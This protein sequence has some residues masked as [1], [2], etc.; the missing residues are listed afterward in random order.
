MDNMINE[1][2]GRRDFIGWAASALSS[3]MAVQ[4]LGCD[5]LNNSP[6]GEL[7][8]RISDNH[9]HMAVISEAQL[10][11]GWA[12]TLHIQGSADHDHTV[13]FTRQDM[14]NI[15]SGMLVSGTSSTSNGHSHVV[16]FD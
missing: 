9:G 3:V 5:A 13:D 4:I 16:S 15:K 10:N 7:S 14:A 6:A 12:L 11:D 1:E 2:M 8:G